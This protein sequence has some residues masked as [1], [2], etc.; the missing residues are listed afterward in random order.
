MLALP[1]GYTPYF[2][3]S[4][5]SN[6]AASLYSIRWKGGNSWPGVPELLHDGKK[7][8]NSLLMS[9]YTYI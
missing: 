2:Y 4:P 5:L 3:I 8:E 9:T 1:I 6:I 7:M